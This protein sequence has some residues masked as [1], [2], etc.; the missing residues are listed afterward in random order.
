MAKYA[1]F[2]T[3]LK[4][5]GTAG[6]AVVNVESIEGPE[7]STEMLDMTAHDSGSAY[8]ETRPSFIDAGEITLRIQWDPN[9]ATHKNAAGGLRY[10][11]AQR[12]SQQFA[13][14]YPS[15]PV[16]YDIFTA[17]VTGFTPSAPFDDK[18]TAEV[19]LTLTG[20]PTLA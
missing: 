19:T 16:A 1:A 13:I 10:L 20:A 2:G 14:A 3:Q 17:Y 7:A 5:G 9:D 8:R 12:T 11:L 6:T 4:I 15:S 18:L